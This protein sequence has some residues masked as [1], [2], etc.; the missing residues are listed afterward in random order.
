[1]E[2]PPEP[3]DKWTPH[4]NKAALYGYYLAI[5][6]FIPITGIITGLLA[7]G[8]GVSGLKRADETQGNGR[9][10]AFV[11]LLGGTFFMILQTAIVLF[12]LLLRT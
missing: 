9:K 2:N 5:F 10:H 12:P 8:F 3:E 11:A 1:M 7:I 4:D 6:S